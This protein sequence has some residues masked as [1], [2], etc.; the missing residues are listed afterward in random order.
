MNQIILNTLQSIGLTEKESQIYLSTL[1]NGTA[2][3]S[4]I[5][6]TAN[7]NRIT[8]YT[9]LEKLQA[10]GMVTLTERDGIKNFTAISPELLVEDTQKKAQDLANKLPLL[11]SIAGEHGSHPAVQFFT[12]LDGVKNSYKSTLLSETE[13]LNYAN[14]KNL[15]DHWP[16]YDEEY[17]KQRANKK[18]FLRGFAP[19]DEPGV[20]VHEDDKKFYREIRLLPKAE[21]W[22]E[23]EINIFDDKVLITSFEPDIFAILIQSKAVADTQRQIFEMMWRKK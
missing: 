2:P 17:V 11:K 9:I 13:I 16:E 8:T 15:R 7:H 6:Q 5:A 4:Q 1:E 10:R 23:N 20:L 19:E 12:G 14:S 21:F 22:V 18:I 3:V